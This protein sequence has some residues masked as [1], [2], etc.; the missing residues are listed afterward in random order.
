MAGHEQSIVNVSVN[1]NR[2]DR[3]SYN[4]YLFEF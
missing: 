2:T 4:G 3:G 1:I